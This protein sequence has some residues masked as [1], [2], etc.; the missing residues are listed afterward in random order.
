MSYCF[1]SR[2]WKIL[3]LHGQEKQLFCTYEMLAGLGSQL[4]QEIKMLQMQLVTPLSQLPKLESD[5]KI[6]YSM[7]YGNSNLLMLRAQVCFKL[8][9]FLFGC[10]CNLFMYP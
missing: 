10:I 8:Q 9:V 6:L 7:M 5:Q 3:D 4:C 1:P 2:V